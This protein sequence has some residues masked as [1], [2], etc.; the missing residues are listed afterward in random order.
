MER[1]STFY[2]IP[3]TWK[4]SR[5]WIGLAL[6]TVIIFS[7]FYSHSASAATITVNSTADVVADDGMC[8]LREA[9]TAANADT[10]SG[11]TPGECPAGSGSDVVSIP[12]GYYLLS[13]GV[14]MNP[15]TEMEIVG[16]GQGLTVINGMGATQIF[17]RSGSSALVEIREMTLQGGASSYG[18]AF[19]Q[20]S[21]TTAIEDVTFYNN[22]VVGSGGAIY[23]QGDPLQQHHGSCLWQ[24]KWSWYSKWRWHPRC[25]AHLVFQ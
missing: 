7:L 19:R 6:F 3:Q 23:N 18:A 14:A 20:A 8:T 17:N 2:V 21:Q 22:S 9:I 11:A 5:A 1:T 13:P 16:A 12:A 24:F 4:C 15:S 25:Y 10:P